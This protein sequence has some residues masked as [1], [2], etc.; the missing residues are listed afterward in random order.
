MEISCVLKYTFGCL[1]ECLHAFSLLGVSSFDY[2]SWLKVST[3]VEGC[4]TKSLRRQTHTPA[5]LAPHIQPFDVVYCL[6]NTTNQSP[7]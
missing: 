4:K 5:V 2:G 7:F 6:L 3:G 1:L